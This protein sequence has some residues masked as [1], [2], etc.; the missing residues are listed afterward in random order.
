[1]SITTTLA[2]AAPIVSTT[3]TFVIAAAVFVGFL[4]LPMYAG[5]LY[6]F[7]RMLLKEYSRSAARRV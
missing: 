5:Y 1:M 4:V 3:M 7:P 2:F 6:T